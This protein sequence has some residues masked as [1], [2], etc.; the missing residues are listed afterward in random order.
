MASAPGRPFDDAARIMAD[1]Q[2]A[3]EHAESDRGNREEVH[4][5]NG[6]SMVAEKGAPT[7]ANA[8]LIRSQLDRVD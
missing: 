3:V 5:R 4:G 8:I 1:H 6:F 7:V 2:K